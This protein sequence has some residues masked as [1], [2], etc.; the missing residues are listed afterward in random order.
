[1]RCRSARRGRD[2]ELAGQCE[3]HEIRNSEFFFFF[4]CARELG[5]FAVIGGGLTRGAVSLKVTVAEARGLAA[6]DETSAKAIN[7]CCFPRLTVCVRICSV[8]SVL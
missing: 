1:L 5:S 6:K 2:A 4:F 8:G 7:A 3:V